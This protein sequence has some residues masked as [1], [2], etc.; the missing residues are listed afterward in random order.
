M[1]AM[2]SQSFRRSAEDNEETEVRN[3]KS[4]VRNQKSEVRNQK[5][6]VRNNLEP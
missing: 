3:Q 4:E 1:K 5:S 2:R 6:E